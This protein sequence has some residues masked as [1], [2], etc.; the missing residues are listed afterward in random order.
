[1]NKKLLLIAMIDFLDRN[2]KQYSPG[3]LNLSEEDWTALMSF[4]QSTSQVYHEENLPFTIEEVKNQLSYLIN[5][6]EGD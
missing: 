3:N 5:N 4:I 6:Q 2:S 1:M